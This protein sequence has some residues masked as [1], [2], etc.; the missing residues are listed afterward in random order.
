MSSGTS[1]T[2]EPPHATTGTKPAKFAEQLPLRILAA[3]DMATNRDVLRF[4]CRHLGYQIEVVD[5]G[6]DALKCIENQP[7]DLVL[8][9]IQMPGMNGAAVAEELCRRQPNPALRPKLVAITAGLHVGGRERC[10]SAGM[11]DY[12]PKP[13]TPRT[14]QDCFSRLFLPA[15]APDTA[16]PI[17]APAVPWIDVPHLRAMTEGLDPQEA[18]ASL[19]ALREGVVADVRACQIRLV[20]A[21]ASQNGDELALVAHGLK[22]CVVTLGWSRFGRHCADV[23]AAVRAREFANW[24]ALPREIDYLFHASCTA[25]DS[26]LRDFGPK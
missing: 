8:L 6:V 20:A 16:T 24:T 22:G 19:R 7:Y 17:P 1:S 5:N 9:D 2:P 14:L 11:D 3:D 26:A 12:L 21:C 25:F 15:T 4:M 23:V 18:K 13:V 10:L